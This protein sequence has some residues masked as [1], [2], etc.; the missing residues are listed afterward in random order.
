M[1]LLQR[2]ARRSATLCG[3]NPDPETK[4]WIDV[5]AARSGARLAIDVKSARACAYSVRT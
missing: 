3:L 4:R 1:A 2:L 5:L